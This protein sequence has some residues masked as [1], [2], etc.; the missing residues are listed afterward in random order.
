MRRL[1]ARQSGEWAAGSDR[2]HA[3]HR[4]TGGA[5]AA[6]AFADQAQRLAAGNLQGY[7]G[8]SMNDLGANGVLDDEVIDIE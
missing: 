4:Q 3:Q 8:N 7:A 2:R 6:A 1:S 5:L